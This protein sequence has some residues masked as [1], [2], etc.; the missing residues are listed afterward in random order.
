MSFFRNTFARLINLD[1]LDLRQQTK[2]LFSSF[3]KYLIWIVS[4]A[5]SSAK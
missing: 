4:L 3:G 5:L 2:K 1:R